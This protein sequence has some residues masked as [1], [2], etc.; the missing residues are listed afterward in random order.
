MVLKL[1]VLMFHHQLLQLALPAP[2]LQGIRAPILHNSR[3]SNKDIPLHQSD[4]R[5]LPTHM[6]THWKARAWPRKGPRIN[7]F[8]AS[9]GEAI[10]RL[11]PSSTLQTTCSCGSWDSMAKHNNSK[12]SG[13]TIH[14]PFTKVIIVQG[15]IQA[16]NERHILWHIFM[17]SLNSP[18][19]IFKY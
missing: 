13:F 3:C 4:T 9:T 17:S 7:I 10:L 1:Y 2:N 6:A 11:W 18:A 8:H 16:F 5:D 14:P 19:K 12:C 15:S